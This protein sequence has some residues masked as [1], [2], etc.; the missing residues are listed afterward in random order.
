M[1]KFLKK[2]I[3]T[4]IAIGIILVLAVLVG[5]FTLWQY[6]KM[7]KEEIGGEINIPEKSEDITQPKKTAKY[8]DN[9]AKETRDES[10]C[11]MI[12]VLEPRGVCYSDL[13]ILKNEPPICWK[14]ETAS[15]ASSC[16]EYF[17]MKDWKIYRNEEYGFKMSYPKGWEI[18]ESGFEIVKVKKENCMFEISGEI[19]SAGKREREEGISILVETG[20]SLESLTINTISLEKVRCPKGTNPFL[21]E[22]VITKYY[23]E[24]NNEYYFLRT[25]DLGFVDS[26]EDSIRCD[27]YFN[28]M[29][30]TFKFID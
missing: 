29:V 12:D 9:L 5:G 15:L 6:S 10:Y 25:W 17:G 27:D 20:C 19:E 30:S 28:Q 3:S 26:L 18:D 7:Q 11:G 23:F 4:P 1:L 2:G 8:Y 21:E 22:S 13:A 16:W 24:K 14:V